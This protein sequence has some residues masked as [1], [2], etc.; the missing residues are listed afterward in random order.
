MGFLDRAIKRG[1]NR[2]VNNAVSNVVER[3]ANEIL[4]PQV[5]KGLNR[6]ADAVTQ[7]S[8]IRPAASGE[9][10]AGTAGRS[11]LESAAVLGNAFAGFTGAAQSYA[12]QAAK[13]MKIC[14]ACGTSA[15]ADVKF[16]PSCGGK[17]PEMT[18]AQGA[19][20]TACGHENHVCVRFC[21]A[22]G[23]KLP[24]ALAE[25]AAAAEKDNGVLAEWQRQLPVFPVWNHGGHDFSLEE[26]GRGED[27]YPQV[28]FSAR[29]VSF[30][31]LQGYLDLLR[32]NGFRPAG[33]YPSD[34]VLYKM[35]KG[36]CWMFCASEA[37]AGGTGV[38]DVSFSTGEPSGGFNYVKQEPKK[39]TSFLDFFK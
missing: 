36:V 38:L 2:A 17:L 10:A 14:P 39:S 27:G 26:I 18:L 34:D 15:G 32:S 9:T 4:A 25:E 21:A 22:C 8:G 37:F 11:S 13:N 28:Q 30:A 5:E 29:E 3:K 6:A 12:D 19:V 20:C 23:A 1:V 35:E 31:M 24:A 7:A 16:C 33:R